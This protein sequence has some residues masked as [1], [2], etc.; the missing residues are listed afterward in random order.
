MTTWA[1]IRSSQLLVK[2]QL[3]MTTWE[4]IRSSQGNIWDVSMGLIKVPIDYA[5]LFTNGESNCQVG[6]Y[7]T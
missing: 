7:Q 3:G 2:K 4:D 6:A 5:K 1:D